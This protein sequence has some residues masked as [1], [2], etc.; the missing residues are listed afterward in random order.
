MFES[1]DKVLCLIKVFAI[2]MT[3]IVLSTF[4]I[5]T[6]IAWVVGHTNA[7]LLKEKGITMSWYHAAWVPSEYL[8]NAEIKIKQ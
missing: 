6:P 7:I 5:L 3:F 4:L 8:I 1:H 2:V